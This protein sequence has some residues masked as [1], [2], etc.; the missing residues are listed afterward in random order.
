MALPLDNGAGGQREKPGPVHVLFKKLER[1]ASPLTMNANLGGG[2]SRS[3]L[4]LLGFG[5]LVLAS[6]TTANAYFF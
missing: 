4:L 2:Q 3:N 6:P 5:K 1:M